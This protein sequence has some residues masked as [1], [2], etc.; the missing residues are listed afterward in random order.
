M[1]M[2]MF[3]NQGFYLLLGFSLVVG[4]SNT[5]PIIPQPLAI[6]Q[7]SSSRS[8]G[9]VTQLAVKSYMGTFADGAT[10]L[11]EVPKNW[12]R[13]FLL[14]SHGYVG[15]PGSPNPADDGNNSFGEPAHSYLL[16][17]GY[18]LGGSSYSS[19]GYV[20]HDALL[21]QIAVLDTFNSV[22]GHP[23]RTIAW[24]W[25][26]GGLIS[27]GLIQNYPGRFSGALSFC[28]ILAGSVAVFNQ[29]VD[30]A[31]A[32]NTL[33]AS[34]QL[35]VVH[36]TNPNRD[37]SIANNALTNA[38]ASPQGR[39][40]IDLVAALS[41]LPGWT[42]VNT[43]NPNPPEP[44]RMDYAAREA[45]NF[46][47][48]Q[49]NFGFLFPIRQDFEARAG[50]NP[51]WNTGLDYRRQLERSV[52]YIEVKTLYAQ[53]G[54]SLDADLEA[55]NNAPRITADPAALEYATQNVTFNG[56]IAVPVLT[57][58]TIGD[59][60]AN[61]QNE[62]AYAAVVRDGHDNNL[63]RERF[64]HRP[65]HLTFTSAEIIVGL[66]ALIDRVDS[67]N[68]QGI[69]PQDLNRAALELGPKFNSLFGGGPPEVPAFTEYEPAPFLRT[70]D[71]GGEER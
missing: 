55:L 63:V 5:K 23:R 18:A 38:Q 54:L 48:L 8:S 59:D 39:A 58:H 27:A 69:Q 62:Q 35:E 14:W 50:G 12:N 65:S 4:C 33:L 24:G 36:I 31:F 22:V 19:A 6:A 32:L 51:S 7:L 67:R 16:S 47:S 9:P 68:W 10:Y 66:Q 13:T 3:A 28:G 15:P 40:R 26:M 45:N 2:K 25:S 57:V 46:A 60:V 29:W 37:I 53:A 52:D 56:V 43:S 49:S 41:D 1:K 30:Q 61:V 11:I 70:F 21:D 44:G 20:V 17:H 64:V 42:N 34:G 71:L